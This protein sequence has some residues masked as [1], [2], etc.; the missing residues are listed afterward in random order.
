VV[1]V[2]VS[3]VIPVN[4]S[5]AEETDIINLYYS[6]ESIENKEDNFEFDYLS[7]MLDSIISDI[8][9]GK[10]YKTDPQFIE[11]YMAYYIKNLTKDQYCEK[12]DLP[13]GIKINLDFL[14]NSDLK[15]ILMRGDENTSGFWKIKINYSVIS[16][17][18]PNLLPTENKI[19]HCDFILESL[20]GDKKSYTYDLPFNPLKIY[21][22]LEKTVTSDFLS[23]F[24]GY[25]YY[26]LY[27]RSSGSYYVKVNKTILGYTN[28]SFLL[29]QG[30]Y[31]ITV[32]FDGYSPITRDI[33]LNQSQILE[34]NLEKLQLNATLTINT[35]PANSDVFINNK[36]IGKSP[37]IKHSIPEGMYFITVTAK[38]FD[39]K[40]IMVTLDKGENKELSIMLMP[41]NYIE[42]YSDFSMQYLNKAYTNMKWSGLFLLG[43]FALIAIG[44]DYYRQ[45]LAF[46]DEQ[47]YYLSLVWYSAGAAFG[48][49]SLTFFGFGFYDMILY[50]SIQRYYLTE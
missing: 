23:D 29:K 46:S 31:S 33:S 5:A 16:Q 34:I 45:A 3:F 9:E 39:N 10:E 7:S 4:C 8:L 27:V 21:D 19:L 26:E 17:E 11:K 38:G 41:D 25:H 43:S 30:E 14:G 32:F 37:V 50:S 49:V 40:E 28:N 24:T 18:K 20:M 36:F 12:S 1:F 42:Y 22:S 48:G 6:I 2:V 35:F 47:K 15:F 13:A 44:N